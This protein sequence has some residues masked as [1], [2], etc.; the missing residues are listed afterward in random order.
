MSTSRKSATKD[1]DVDADSTLSIEV[2]HL[3]RENPRLPES[4]QNRPEREILEYFH[5][6]GNLL[7]LAESFLD[8]GYFV[9]EPLIV[10][11]RKDGEFDVL[12]G[13]RRLATLLILFHRPI[14]RGLDLAVER[15]SA[16]LAKLSRPKV[17]ET[18]SRADVGPYVGFRH[19]GGMK[20][21][22]A[23]AKSRYVFAEIE[24][25]AKAREPEPFRKL[26][27]RVGSTP[28]AMRASYAATALL[29]LAHDEG[30]FDP[31]VLVDERRFGVWLRAY[32]APRIRE[33][34][35]FGDPTGYEEVKKALRKTDVARLVEVLNDFVA[36]DGMP[37]VMDDSRDMTIYAAV[38]VHPQARKILRRTRSLEAAS[39]MVVDETLVANLSKLT[40]RLEAL[41]DKAVQTKM[42]ESSRLA[43]DEL[44]SA[45]RKL[46][47]I[48]HRAEDE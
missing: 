4:L 19:I 22:A 1:N 31:Q 8:N 35:R 13:N 48:I 20:K 44:L 3:D 36:I 45:A 23:E 7:E 39:Y 40:N 24:V 41:Q 12:E 5:R 28:R 11:R 46:H 32:D 38:L 17:R 37:P 21:W 34:I 2:L 26:A 14:A 10:H 15:S 29:R 6:E 18:A 30:D 47:A 9:E 43:V 33:Y 27:R 42:D 25:L 16:Q